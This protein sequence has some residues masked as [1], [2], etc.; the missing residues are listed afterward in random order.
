MLFSGFC[1][2]EHFLKQLLEWETK[3]I[4]F[5]KKIIPMK[6]LTAQESR[7]D[8][9]F[10][11][12]YFCR[13]AFLED[14]C[15]WCKV[16]DHDH[17]TG[18]FPGAAHRKCNIELPEKYLIPVFFHNFRGYDSHLIVHQFRYYKIRS[19]KVIGQ[20]MKKYL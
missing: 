16:R 20:N 18:N 2:L 1:A 14:Y 19:I 11:Y 12:C 6:P 3:C 13:F 4:K 7:K 17:L 10:K 5:I 9:N 15:R 8:E